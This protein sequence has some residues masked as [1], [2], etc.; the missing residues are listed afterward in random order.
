MLA[1]G[2]TYLHCLKQRRLPELARNT[3]DEKSIPA[4]CA[5]HGMIQPVTVLIEFY[6]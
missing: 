5:P 2:L 6:E 4:L 1:L 3:I